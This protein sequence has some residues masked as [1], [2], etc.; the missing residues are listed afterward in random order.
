[1][2]LCLLIL[3]P[4]VA[5]AVLLQTNLLNAVVVLGVFSLLSSGI[6]LL[7]GA[8]DVAVTEGAIGVA[9]V[10]FIYVIAL[11]NRGKLKVV[12][13]EVPGFLFSKK[14]RLK[15]VDYEI[16]ESFAKGMDLQLE[17]EFVSGGTILDHYYRESQDIIA[18]AFMPT[19]KGKKKLTF[20]EEYLQGD[21]FEIYPD[22]DI[23]R[24]KNMGTL[25]KILT[26]QK[27]ASKW[28]DQFPNLK[29]YD[30]LEDL[31]KGYERGN[32]SK[33]II[34]SARLPKIISYLKIIGRP[35][36]YD[37][38]PLGEVTYVFAVDKSNYELYQKLNEHIKKLK[39]EGELEKLEIKY[40]GR[41]L[42]KS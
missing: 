15:G 24:I 37:L 20:S 27:F 35:R 39:R 31:L 11:S 29:V 41:T 2:L 13:E 18:G 8:P 34:D 21:L 9:L 25:R 1:M 16:L 12:G 23:R 22:E 6:Y 42:K 10:T 33:L 30:E 5:I 40:L 14:G 17:V 4:I 28:E 3:I 32:I 36:R 38:T 19:P 26:H 7:L